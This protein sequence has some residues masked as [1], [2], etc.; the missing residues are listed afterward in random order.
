MLAHYY[1]ADSIHMV[2][3]VQIIHIFVRLAHADVGGVGG[4][5]R[6]CGVGFVIVRVGV[7]VGGG[8]CRR[9]ELL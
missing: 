2:H 7:G 6:P 3:I 1:S 9:L 4:T 5:C 8:V